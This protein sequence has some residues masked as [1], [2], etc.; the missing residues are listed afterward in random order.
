[1]AELMDSQLYDSENKSDL[2]SI[3]KDI[4][5]MKSPEDFKPECKESFADMGGCQVEDMWDDTVVNKCGRM[6]E[7][8]NPIPVIKE[9]EELFYN[10]D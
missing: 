5:P 2:S 3:H 9:E 8:T 10:Q 6:L 4:A 1:M 7:K